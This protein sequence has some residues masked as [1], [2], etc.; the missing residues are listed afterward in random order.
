[1]AN[2]SASVTQAE[3]TR[4]LRAAKEAGLEVAGYEVDPSS[5]KVRVFTTKNGAPPPSEQDD[6][7]RELADF[8]A[9]DGH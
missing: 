1:M 4:A 2:K 8:E 9:R 3:I 5:G 7:D 6:L